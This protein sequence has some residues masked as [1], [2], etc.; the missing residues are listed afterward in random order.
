MKLESTS[1]APSKSEDEKKLRAETEEFI[2]LIGEWQIK[3]YAE[4]KRSLLVILQ[5]LDASGKDGAIKKVFADVNPM[6]IRVLSFKKPTETELSYDFL[7]RVHHV[8]PPS[9]MIHVFNRSHYEDILVPTVEGYLPASFINKRYQQINH[10]E[11]LLEESG[12]AVLKFML[13]VSEDEQRDRLKER[14]TDP[15]KF[16]KHKDS[17]W[18]TLKK[19]KAYLEVY[20][21]I[22]EKC[23]DCKWHVIPSDKNWYKEY[24]I[25]KAVKEKL[26]ELNPGYPPLVTS[27]KK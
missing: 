12:T 1:A 20:D 17:D 22:L 8:V 26:E 14:M 6:G 16:W 23:D 27:M 13:H 19:R 24:L 3:L 25:A 11:K 2:S 21:E 18:E 5:G 7:W 9:G 15:K 10:F 4:N